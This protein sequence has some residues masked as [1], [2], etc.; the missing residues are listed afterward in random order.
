MTTIEDRPPT[1]TKESEPLIAD[2]ESARRLIIV[3]IGWL[4]LAK[5]APVAIGFVQGFATGFV[6]GL[7][8]GESNLEISADLE[9]IPDCGGSIWF[10]YRASLRR[11]NQGPYRGWR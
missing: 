8:K 3:A 11:F 7:S 9:P 5:A 2:P 1:P 10:C 4:S 6:S